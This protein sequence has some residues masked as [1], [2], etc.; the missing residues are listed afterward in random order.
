MA[1]AH[2]EGPIRLRY[3]R[4][5]AQLAG[6][7]AQSHGSAQLLNTFLGAH[8]RDHR[9]LALGRELARIRIGQLDDV[10]RELDDR[11]LQAEAD[12]EERELVFPCPADRLEHAF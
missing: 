8:Q 2:L 3:A 9:V 4:A 1:L 10:T 5:W 11:R 6:I 7:G 12:A